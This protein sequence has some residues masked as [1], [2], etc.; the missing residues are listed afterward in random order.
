MSSNKAHSTQSFCALVEA[1][2]A[3]ANEKGHS[4]TINYRGQEITARPGDEVINMV[5][6]WI[7]AARLDLLSL[8]MTIRDFSQEVLVTARA[9][10]IVLPDSDPDLDLASDQQ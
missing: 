10:D 4:V 7:E 5:E 2:L 9:G 8:E 3:L 1:A 6:R